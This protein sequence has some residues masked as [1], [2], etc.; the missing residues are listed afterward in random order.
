ML[1]TLLL[2]KNL[3]SYYLNHN[4]YR[5]KLIIQPNKLLNLMLYAAIFCF[6]NKHIK[7]QL[8]LNFLLSEKLRLNYICLPLPILFFQNQTFLIY[9]LQRG[10]N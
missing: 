1:P 10:P 6:P 9:S 5:L 8:S 2:V 7:P 4:E 3:K